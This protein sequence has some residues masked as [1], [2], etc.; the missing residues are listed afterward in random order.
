MAR[1]YARPTFCRTAA[2][3]VCIFSLYW[4]CVFGAPGQTNTLIFEAE[5]FR[6][7]NRNWK[8]QPWGENYY[9]ATF[10]NTFLSR[11]AFLQ[12]PEQCDSSAASLNI[13][14]PEAGRYLALVRYEAAYR[15]ETRFQ[16]II[17]QNDEP[18]L[19]RLYGARDNIKIWA[20][21]GRLTNEVAWS[22]GA[23]ENIV[24]EGHDA[25]VDL[26]AGPAKLTLIAER[27][28][29]PA[30]QRNVDVVML[31]SDLQKVQARIAKDEYLPLD[32]LLTQSGDL[33]L[34]AQSHGGK[35][36]LDIPPGTEHSPY[37]VHKREWKPVTLRVNRDWSDWMEVGGVL[38][39]LNDGQWHL[40][41]K[42]SARA[43]YDVEFAIRSAAGRYQTIGSFRQVQGELA[44]V[45]DGDV[46]HSRRIRTE[47]EVLFELVDYL[48]KQPYHGTVPKRTLIYGTT[49]A[50]KPR[51]AKYT[52]ALAEFQNLL[53]A[54]ALSAGGVDK[55]PMDGLIRGYID[56]RDQSP[57]RLEATCKKLVA[58]KK[59][60]RIAVVSLGDEIG[61]STPS[62]KS[63]DVFRAWLKAKGFKP[64]ELD[65]GASNDWEQIE[66]S[67]N[68]T[69]ARSK[70]GLYYASQLYRNHFGI[71]AQ[72]AKTDVLRKWLPNALI[73]ANYSPHHGE[74]YLGETHKWVTLF[75]ES[76]MTMP[77]SEDYIFQVPVGSQQM[78]FLS[79]DLF[80]AGIRGHPGAKI[81]FYV[82][83]HWPGNTPENWRR[84]F[85]GD[86]GHGAKIFN[87]FEFRPVQA[88]YTENHCSFPEMYAEVGR[89]IHELGLFEDIVQDG[90]VRA[91]VAGLWFSEAGD[92]WKDNRPPFAAAKRT[93]Y[94]A[95]RHQQLPVDVVVEDDP[96]EK[97]QI[98][99]L[100]DAHV[101]RAASKAIREWVKTG[102]RLFV[103]AG[104]GMYDEFNETNK[105]FQELLG[106][107][108]LKIVEDA[109]PVRFE[110]QDLPFVEP[111]ETVT[112]R[113]NAIPVINVFA[114]IKTNSAKVLGKFSDGSPAVTQKDTSEGTAIYCAF[115]PG[116]SYFKPA[117]PMRP[118]DR[119]SRND[120]LAHFIPTN[121][122]PRASELVGSIIE[123]ERPLSCSNP[124]VE[125]SIIQAPY[126]M[127][128]PLIN[129]SAGPIR[130]LHVTMN[131][132]V[133]TR[134]VSSASGKPVRMER[135]D[136]K[137]VFALPLEVADV[138]ILR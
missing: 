87:L 123:F 94:I 113:S 74:F 26:D 18:K 85:Y 127:A 129:W 116:L 89:S 117:M 103:T 3:V 22:W 96:L 4:L 32:A 13:T 99:Y 8:R 28:P 135:N 21:G 84:Q 102:G 44:L 51:D 11:K 62:G 92:I 130:N 30:A 81:Q 136:G 77:W 9:C 75:R 93:L 112:W 47:D 24:W 70:P 134:S 82:M 2:E 40:S 110:K 63:N 128:I 37:W 12:A 86:I 101:S 97:Y 58:E 54:T 23:S 100:T 59:A 53:G 57:E 138:L 107:Q 88:A 31:T 64:S 137:L 83:P 121:F 52:A 25:F 108:Q 68:E 45:Y 80:R 66:F 65:K 131:V 71:Q 125:S 34:R 104:G 43:K 98:L 69:T 120:C 60:D 20:F 67:P 46:R 105:V 55:I 111:V 27:Q 119:G 6:A 7:A 42:G 122:H 90:T 15:F 41:P 56:V 1:G 115:L 36:E 72:K 61:L 78:N 106:I 39:S 50:E 79:L 91:G 38:D 126:A 76:G 5:D 48:K 118:V 132:P 133:P 73:G 19:D 109:N 17:E 95:M 114:Q 49:F 16:L 35:F 29:E 33:Y 14:V 10:A 124:L